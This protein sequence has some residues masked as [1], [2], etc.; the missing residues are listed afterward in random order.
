[1][2]ETWGARG[3]LLPDLSAELTPSACALPVQSTS[4]ESGQ[5][6]ADDPDRIQEGPRRGPQGPGTKAIRRPDGAGFFSVDAGVPSPE[7][8]PSRSRGGRPGVHP[9]SQPV[10]NGPAGQFHTVVQ[11]QLAQQVRHMFAGGA[12]GDAQQLR[13]LAV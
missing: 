7:A 10:P 3:R 8:R 11:A 13:D 4:P 1:M 6:W 9:C 5:S 12:G 2:P